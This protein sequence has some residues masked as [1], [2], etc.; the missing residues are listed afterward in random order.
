LRIV[1]FGFQS[2]VVLYQKKRDSLVVITVSTCYFVTLAIRRS[3]LFYLRVPA[4]V[5]HFPGGFL[6]RK[7]FP[8]TLLPNLHL[9][10]SL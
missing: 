3:I 6:E 5:L 4:V 8:F 7:I 1:L 10:P 2:L 9:A